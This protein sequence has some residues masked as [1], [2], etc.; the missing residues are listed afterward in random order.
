MITISNKLYMMNDPEKVSSAWVRYLYG[1]I[2]QLNDRNADDWNV[3]PGRYIA[4]R[5]VFYLYL[6]QPDKEHNHQH[7]RATNRIWSKKTY[8][9]SGVMSDDVSLSLHWIDV[10]LALYILINSNAYPTGIEITNGDHESLHPF[11][12]NTQK[13]KVFSETLVPKGGVILTSY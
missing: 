13:P 5:W 7:R 9:L 3:P 11:S 1:L 4:W 12:L 10:H 2:E 8:R 6:L